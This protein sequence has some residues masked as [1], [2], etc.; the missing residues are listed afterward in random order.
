MAEMSSRSYILLLGI[1]AA[2]LLLGSAA[3]LYGGGGSLSLSNSTYGS[4][5]VTC[6]YGYICGMRS[7]GCAIMGAVYN[8]PNEPINLSSN[9]ITI[10]VN[11]TQELNNSATQG[12]ALNRSRFYATSASDCSRQLISWCDNNVPSQF[13][14]VNQQSVGVVSSQYKSAHSTPTACPD[15]ILA[16]SVSCGLVNNYCVVTYQKSG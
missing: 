10:A 12:F 13:I 8:C 1:A 14:C 5:T 7:S 9:S 3:V 11:L 6:P 15:F 4:N 16:G 2:V